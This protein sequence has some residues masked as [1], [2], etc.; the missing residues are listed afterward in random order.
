MGFANSEGDMVLRR[1]RHTHLSFTLNLMLLYFKKT[2]TIFIVIK[3][4]F[5]QILMNV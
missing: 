2:Y 3:S 5:I 1:L 4:T